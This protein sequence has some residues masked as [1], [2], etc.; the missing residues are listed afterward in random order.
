M[1]T[2]RINGQEYTSSLSDAEIA[3][4]GNFSLPTTAQ[5]LSGAIAEHENDISELNSKLDNI[6]KYYTGSWTAESSAAN[7]I[8]LTSKISLPKGTYVIIGCAPVLSAEDKPIALA[9]T[10]SS[11]INAVGTYNT[12]RS[13]SV[14]AF[15]VDVVNDT[16]VWLKTAY[17]S[18]TTYTNINDSKFRAIRIS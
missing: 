12:I 11:D 17:S 8:Q 18:S 4:M 7:N 14:I 10:S 2:V 5:T 1:N 6:G 9:A 13:R 16:Q 15:V 3:F